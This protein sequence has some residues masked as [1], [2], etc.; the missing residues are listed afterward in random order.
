[1]PQTSSLNW[2]LLG[3]GNMKC[4]GNVAPLTFF[5]AQSVLDQVVVGLSRTTQGK[6]PEALDI[7]RSALQSIPLGVAADAK[8]EQKFL[9]LID[10]CREYTLAM[11]VEVT[12]KLLDASETAR[13]LELAAYLTCC[14]MQSSHV[15]LMLRVGMSVAYKAQNF[16]TAAS[17]AKRIVQGNLGPA[18][19]VAQARKL[20]QAC[21]QKATD[22]HSIR[23]DVRAPIEDFKLC[24]GSLT[25]VAPTD[26]T[27]KCPFC[28]AV[29]HA[30]YKGNLCDI[31][32]LSE[33]GANTLGIQLRPL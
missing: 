14:K 31:C 15:L 21:E 6:C 2:P 11:R 30:K 22:A 27:E 28:G 24:A 29:Y 20:L 3:E 23:Y 9:E 33:I 32:Q 13:I 18:D 1:M 5:T 7:F 4:S 25:P 12:R 19:V 17:F 10:M 26:T 8:E 16:V